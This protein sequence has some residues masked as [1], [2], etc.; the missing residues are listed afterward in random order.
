VREM[1]ARL[2][3]KRWPAAFDF[4]LRVKLNQG[5]DIIRSECVAA[6]TRP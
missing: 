4:L 1:A 6:R 3:D 5:L 2:P